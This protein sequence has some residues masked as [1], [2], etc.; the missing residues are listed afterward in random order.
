MKLLGLITFL[1][2]IASSLGS[3]R[4]D[5]HRRRQ[6]VEYIYKEY[7][8]VCRM[9]SDGTGG[10]KNGV[11]YDLYKREDDSNVDY[12]WCKDKCNSR[13]SCTGFEYRDSGDTSQCEVWKKPIGGFEKKS[14]HDCMVRGDRA[15]SYY[16]EYGACRKYTD[17]TGQGNSGDE[18]E[19][20][21]GGDLTYSKCKIMCSEDK[22]CKGFEYRW[23]DD[24]T[25]Q[26]EL[27]TREI[28]S[29]QQEDKW[30][31]D[32]CLKVYH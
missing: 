3:L 12:H 14:G 13:S 7:P 30:D 29:I 2:A 18:Y 28:K 24:N 27:W 16:C 6:L 1:V 20:V 4:G 32:C 5:G 25:K 8:G 21:K 10:G 15:H 22:D 31:L 17:G 11:E 9:N 26:C 19:L 23:G